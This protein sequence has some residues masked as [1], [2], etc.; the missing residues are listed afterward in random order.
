MY[1]SYMDV[2]RTV[3]DDALGLYS[4]IRGQLLVSSVLTLLWV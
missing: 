4:G 2:S 1:A 3:G